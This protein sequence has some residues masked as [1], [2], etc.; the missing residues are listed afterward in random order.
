MIVVFIRWESRIEDLDELGL[1]R[2]A[3]NLRLRGQQH[4]RS[5]LRD[6]TSHDPYSDRLCTFSISKHS[7]ATRFPVQSDYSFGLFG[8]VFEALPHD[9]PL[10]GRCSFGTYFFFVTS[11]MVPSL[12]L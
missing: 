1:R 3:N 5:H 7:T 4:K 11:R 10:T 8:A 9:S 6:L 12:R 2:R